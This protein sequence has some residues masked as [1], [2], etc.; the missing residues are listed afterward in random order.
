VVRRHPL[1]ATAVGG[2]GA[3]LLTGWL[4]TRG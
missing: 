2:F 1:P 4:L 3:G